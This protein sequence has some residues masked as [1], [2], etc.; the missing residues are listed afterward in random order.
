MADRLQHFTQS[1]MI[2]NGF[3]VALL[4]VVVYWNEYTENKYPH[5]LGCRS[6]TAPEPIE[7]YITAETE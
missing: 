6:G 5:C 2:A 1:Q 3:I 4:L 7:A